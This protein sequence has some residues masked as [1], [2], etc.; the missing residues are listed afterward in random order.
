M[1]D[2]GLSYLCYSRHHDDDAVC[3]SLMGDGA[4]RLADFFEAAGGIK[5]RATC[6]MA[7]GYIDAPEA[8][9]RY[10]TALSG[11]GVREFTFKHTYVAWSRSVYGGSE[12]NRWAQ[13]NRV[14]AG[15]PFIGRGEVVAS[16]PVGAGN[17]RNWRRQGRFL[18]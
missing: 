2:A 17:S 14:A 11:Y 18:L 1:A 4:P 8:V 6:V 13:E 5:V 3:R 7:R 10:M 12:Q 16:L 9:D 15:D